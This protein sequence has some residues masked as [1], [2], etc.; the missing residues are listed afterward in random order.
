M[1]LS[2]AYKVLGL[3]PGASKDELK[4]AYR[5]LALVWHPDRFEHNERL[6]QKAER[7]LKRINEAFALLKDYDPSP[8]D[9]IPSRL[10][11]TF[12]AVLDLGDVLATKIPGLAARP[13]P[14]QPHVVLGLGA[15]ERT[16]VPRHR[17]RRS[18][19][20]I[21]WVVAAV[22]VIVGLVVALI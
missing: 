22:V 17:R 21:F 10:A 11:Q 1:D 2:R 8:D 14:G 5:D 4:R 3:Y 13:R 20:W 6:A 15:I 18:R 16:G 9:P 19:R 7:N 12:S